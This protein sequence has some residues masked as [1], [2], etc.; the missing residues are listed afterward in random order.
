MQFEVCTGVFQFS[1]NSAIGFGIF[2]AKFCKKYRIVKPGSLQYIWT[3]CIAMGVKN[4]ILLLILI[5]QLLIADKLSVFCI[6]SFITIV[7]F[8]IFCLIALFYLDLPDFLR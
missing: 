5:Y 4:V 8:F 3:D 1:N 2:T 7:I 6:I